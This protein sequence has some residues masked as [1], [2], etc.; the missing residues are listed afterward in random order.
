MLVRPRLGAG[1]AHG[2]RVEKS[3]DAARKSACATS[4]HVV[5]RGAT[6]AARRVAQTG[7]STGLRLTLLIYDMKSA[8]WLAALLALPL[9]G[10]KYVEPLLCARC[11]AA[12]A[13]SYARTGMA[14]SFGAVR[15]GTHLAGLEKG[16][17][18]HEASQESFSVVTRD[19][20]PVLRRYQV[21]FEGKVANVFETNIDYWFGSGDHARS[22]ISRDSSGSLIELPIAWY[23]EN[24]G[25][26][27]MSPGFDSAQHSGFS[28]KITDR[29]MFCHTAYTE[30]SRE[31]IDCQ[32]CH[33]PGGDHVE[34]VRQKRGITAIRNAIVNPARLTS[35]R[36]IEV[37]LQ[38]HLETTTLRLPG[39]LVRY[40]RGVFSY[41][42]GEPLGAY[43]LLR[44]RP[45]QGS[46]R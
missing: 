32:R 13:E 20:K 17:F 33:G 5:R 21:G 42:P 8:A 46:R 37:C 3:L 10:A 9:D 6:S 11:H 38:C 18:R 16:N 25:Y 34:A 2:T 44:S 35:E 19:E 40:G 22:Y 12:I 45:G 41:Q 23:A 24:G 15:P 4:L 27:S 1:A 14:R 39:S 29:C 26:W 31:G 28:R 36:R 43:A 7:N 30:R